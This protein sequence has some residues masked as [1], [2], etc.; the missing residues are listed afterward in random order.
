ML[1]LASFTILFRDKSYVVKFQC[2]EQGVTGARDSAVFAMFA[3][4]EDDEEEFDPFKG[5]AKDPYNENIT[6]G[7]LMN[8]SEAEK[9][10]ERFPNHPLTRARQYLSRLK[11]TISFDEGLFKLARFT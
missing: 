2:L 7:V 9:L 1:Y 8:L 5:W 11:E 10:D 3:T 4:F 6:E